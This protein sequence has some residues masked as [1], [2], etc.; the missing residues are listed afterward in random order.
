MA[1]MKNYVQP[2]NTVTFIADTAGVSSGDGVLYGSLFG[3]AATDAVGGE[4][5]EAQVVGVFSLPKDGSAIDPGGK[6]YWTGTA[7]AASGSTLIGVSVEGADASAAT[8]AVR[9]NGVA[10]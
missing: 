9:L 5:Y 7:C 2:G 6:V 1:L 10:I 8:V 4:E 3:V